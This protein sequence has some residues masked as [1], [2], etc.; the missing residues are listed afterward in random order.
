[1]CGCMPIYHGTSK[2]FDLI[3]HDWFYYLPD[4]SVNSIEKINKLIQ[5]DQYKIVAHNRAA[6]SKQID[7]SFSFYKKLDNLLLPNP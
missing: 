4:L 6:I 3:P 2:I 7:Q 1:M 5:T